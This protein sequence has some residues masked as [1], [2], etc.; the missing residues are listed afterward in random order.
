MHIFADERNLQN[1]HFGINY[2]DFDLKMTLQAR[3]VAFSLALSFINLS[4]FPHEKAA[5][6]VFMY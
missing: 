1:E 2:F 4:Y 5:M 3:N 6:Y